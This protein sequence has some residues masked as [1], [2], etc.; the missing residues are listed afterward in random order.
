MHLTYFTVRKLV[1]ELQASL[2]KRRISNAFTAESTDLV[3]QVEGRG[4]LLL[5]A[6]PQDGRV[7][8]LEQPPEVKSAPPDWAER[9]LEK[10]QIE[11]VHQV[12]MDR[13][14]EFALT[15]RDRLGG[16]TRARLI[17]E[18]TGRY[19]NVI[20]TGEPDGRVLGCMR[21]VTSNMSRAREILP[22]KPYR[23]PPPSRKKHVEDVDSTFV[24]EVL[25]GSDD[26]PEVAL[27]RSICSL[28]TLTARE[29]LYRAGGP[30]ADAG[31]LSRELKQMFDTPD[32]LDGAIGF[33][34]PAE[35]TFKVSPIP[36]RHI[37]LESQR[38]FP[39]ASEA[40]EW[41][42]TEEWRLRTGEQKQTRMEKS[43]V[44][45]KASLEKKMEFLER[46]YADAQEA[47]QYEK[48]GNLL[49][50][51][52]HKITPGADSITLEDLFH[53][54][55]PP[56]SIPLQSHRIPLENARDYMKRARKARRAEPIL[57]RR[58]EALRRKGTELTSYFE[59]LRS[60]NDEGD[61][62]RLWDEAQQ[63]GWLHADTQG[64][65]GK[66]R[67]SM[68]GIH[69]RRYLTSEGW[70]V[71]IGRNN[72]E[73]DRLT[74]GSAKEDI[75]LHARG[76]PGSHAILKSDGRTES[77]SKSTLQ[78]AASVAAY[79][80]K[81]R[82][83]KTVPVDYTKVRFVGKPRGSPPGLVSIRNEKT[84]FVQPREIRRADEPV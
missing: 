38:S 76:C 81:A 54:D 21:N 48:F 62:D 77:P 1:D 42:S 67:P 83:S 63:A 47:D 59:R 11:A 35:N 64:K 68:G 69:P 80:S 28:D 55:S 2:V 71:L 44:A 29:L 39:S 36:L 57:T 74:K 25:K 24:D 79:W 26:S 50:N 9:Y 56:V 37:E 27:M 70:L 31:L 72:N 51:N 30:N 66:K 41:A 7:T 4:Y 10:G 53:P 19:A 40:I 82:S 75:F 60:L 73:N 43:L 23:P 13:I 33:R 49:M 12:P 61:L 45:Q 46:A 15:K 52:L 34:D 58:L 3:L 84:L 32:F 20:L 5:S 6:S 14:I 78:E 22:G 16:V 17:A 18:L 8:M 65:K